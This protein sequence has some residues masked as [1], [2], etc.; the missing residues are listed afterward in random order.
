M[1]ITLA[2]MASGKGSNC[3]AVL[4][5]IKSGRLDARAAVILSNKPDAGVL[6]VAREYGV[7]SFAK[8]HKDFP[9]REAFDSEF[10]RVIREA[11]ADTVVLAGYMRILTP[12][13][14]QAYSGRMVNI[15]P[16]LLPSFSGPK[17]ASDALAYGVRL[18]GC[19]VHFVD[20]IA[21]HG[22]VIIQAA[23]PVSSEED[24][25]A[26]M[27]RIHAM[28]HIILPQALQWLSEG[29]L[30]IKDRKVSLLCK[31]KQNF[32]PATGATGINELGPYLIC[33]A[34]DLL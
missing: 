33:P 34:P 23:V 29:R 18:S 6:E 31:K 9:D 24:E 2:I 22:P 17:G 3:R 7:P 26:L 5:A 15:H 20:E 4:E 16:A 1:S 13:F 11:G 12:G 8:S 10:A 30:R 32:L 27:P 19:T 28:E 14:V 25:T 21:D